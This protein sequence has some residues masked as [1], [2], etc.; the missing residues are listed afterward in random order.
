M[1]KIP[2]ES[3]WNLPPKASQIHRISILSIH[4]G[5]KE[6]SQGK[7]SNRREARNLIYDLRA[8]RKARRRKK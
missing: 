2:P 3:S 8:L 7:P 4:C 5:I 1:E 6:D